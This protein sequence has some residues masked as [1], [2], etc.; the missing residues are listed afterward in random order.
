MNASP[1]TSQRSASSTDRALAH[2]RT[3]GGWLPWLGA[4]VGLVW[5]NGCIA[6]AMGFLG[7]SNILALSP[8]LLS[9][10]TLIIVTPALL[11]WLASILARESRRSALA[12]TLVLE[13]SRQLL[14]PAKALE[15][16][17][18][19][20]ASAITKETGR[21]T[22]QTAAARDELQ[23]FLTRYASER[24]E[25]EEALTQ[26]SAQLRTQFDRIKAE[27]EA[28]DDLTD[29]LDR[30]T[31]DM[32]ELLPRQARQMADAAREA[33]QEIAASDT[34]LSERI[35]SMRDAAGDLQEQVSA[36]D[37]LAKAAGQRTTTLA[38]TLQRMDEHL[39]S[40]NSKI[41][42]AAK[43]GE[44]AAKVA[45]ET[46]LSLESAVA[47]ALDNAR[48][49]TSYIKA[50]TDRL[51]AD[52]RGVMADL[53]AAGDQAEKSMKAAGVA[54][55]SN[56]DDIESQ[57]AHV[58]ELLYRAAA[59]AT[60]TAEAGLER[61]RMRI[62]RASAFLTG[63]DSDGAP[64]ADD[65]GFSRAATGLRGLQRD[66]DLPP[67]PK[68]AVHLPEPEPEDETEVASP[69]GTAQSPLPPQ[70]E[71]APVAAGD[72]EFIS[73]FSEATGQ[74]R[75][76]GNLTWRDLLSTMDEPPNRDGDAE[77][78]I[79]HLSK[80]DIRFPDT[81]RNRDTRR[82]AAAAR[83]GEQA[84]RRA[85]LD[86]APRQV[87]ETRELFD[88][89]E[90]LRARAKRFLVVE[91]EDALRALQAT[92]EGKQAPPPRLAAFL[93]LDAALT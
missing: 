66:E 68:P 41:D 28:L 65:P 2:A 71:T 46:G 11:I 50:E 9:G 13:A 74:A 24:A 18:A 31:K 89:Q 60:E 64:V 23:A 70:A 87:N 42:T 7:L 76:K 63:Q 44:L 1:D 92:T 8:W 55:R 33:H 22:A 39:T 62:E 86:A 45:A 40:A 43:S 25:A 38:N 53:E 59:R 67:P 30:Q 84:R 72:D 36:L 93:L 37:T 15:A 49:A 69:A 17:T 73:A 35:A 26:Q 90:E 80:S 51:S 88:T 29:A 78:L 10:G 19:S 85:I 52:M 27:R 57:I 56:A 32:A 3:A 83:K 81:F 77:L 14:N 5:I 20:L 12:N 79:D 91:E 34:A 75:S 21:L 47:N 4:L 58:S 61:A 6:F 48:E 16:D 54:A 82:I